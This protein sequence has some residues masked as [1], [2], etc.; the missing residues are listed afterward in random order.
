MAR[1]L[2]L[3]V[4]AASGSA[5]FCFAPHS[6]RSAFATVSFPF[7]PPHPTRAGWKTAASSLTVLSAKKNRRGATGG[8]KGGKVQ[9]KLLKYVEGTGSIGDVVL[10]APAFYENKLKKTKSAVPISNEGVAAERA[11]DEMKRKEANEAAKQMKEKIEGSRIE[12]SMKAGPD[13]HLFGGVNYK[14]IMSELSKQFPKGA[15][16]KGVKIKSLKSDDGAE[17]PHDIKE[18]GEY[19]A[20]VSLLGDIDAEFT[21]GVIE[22]K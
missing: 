13:G 21:V 14:S 11:E 15:L 5:S 10:V 20:S 16:G 18:L 19:K 2:L 3:A 8:G 6:T 22:A 7:A 12:F 4:L 17:V 9:V 1:V